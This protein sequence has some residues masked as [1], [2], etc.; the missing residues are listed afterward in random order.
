MEF[1]SF[2]CLG[3]RVSNASLPKVLKLQR[4]I[5]PPFSLNLQVPVRVPVKQMLKYLKVPPLEKGVYLHF[6]LVLTAT[7]GNAYSSLASFYR[8]GE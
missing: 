6:L 4:Q 3:R 5:Y 7:L 8:E 2:G 1:N